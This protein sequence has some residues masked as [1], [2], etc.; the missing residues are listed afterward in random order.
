MAS[1]MTARATGS[2][3][4][5]SGPTR[6]ESTTVPLPDLTPDTAVEC[7]CL[8][9]IEA[10]SATIPDVSVTVEP[11]GGGGYGARVGTT[12]TTVPAGLYV[13]ALQTSDGRVLAPVQL[14]LARTEQAGRP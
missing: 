8:V 2:P 10:G 11:L 6:G 12:D 7:S 1:A 14:C 13:G 4:A 5:P 9:S 3:A